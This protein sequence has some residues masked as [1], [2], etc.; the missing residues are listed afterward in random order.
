[1]TNY[2]HLED[3]AWQFIEQQKEKYIR[4]HEKIRLFTEGVYFIL[5]GGCQ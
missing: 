4:N 2:Y 1:M 5:Q 3:R